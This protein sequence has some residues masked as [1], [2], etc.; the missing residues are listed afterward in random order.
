MGVLQ[1]YS[2]LTLTGVSTDLIGPGL[3]PIRPPPSPTS[4]PIAR[5]RCPAHPRLLSMW[6]PIRGSHDLILGCH[7]LLPQLTEL[8]ETVTDVSWFII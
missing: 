6:L 5:N 7:H 4:V 1:S 8:R 2:V 3:S